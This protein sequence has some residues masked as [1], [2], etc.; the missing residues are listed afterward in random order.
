MIQD[1][2]ESTQGYARENSLKYQMMYQMTRITRD[3]G[4]ITQDDR[5]DALA[6]AVGYWATQMAQDAEVKIGERQENLLQKELEDFTDAYYNRKKGKNT[7]R[8]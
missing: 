8:W 2:Y 3:R 7:L 4:A 5:L 6:M 1:D